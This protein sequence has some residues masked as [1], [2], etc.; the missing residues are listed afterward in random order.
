MKKRVADIIV[1]T[2]IEN[3]I[4]QAF[5]VVGGGAMHLNNAFALKRNILRTI[6]NHHE[7]ASAMAAEAYARLTGNLAVVCVTSGPGGLNTFNG[8]QSAWVDSLPMIVIAGHP[9]YDTTINASGLNVRCIGVQENDVIPQVQNITKYAKMVLDPRSVKAEVQKAI[10]LAMDCRRGPVWL[11]FPLDVQGALVEED[12]LYPTENLGLPLIHSAKEGVLEAYSILQASKRPCILTGSGIRTSNSIQEF[13]KFLQLF[14]VPIVGGFG[15]PDNNYNGEKNYFGISGSFGP[16]CGNFILQN[17]DCILV[18]GNSLSTNQT[19]F[20]VSAFAQKAKIIMVDAQEDESK[21]AGLHIKKS[22]VCDIKDFFN[23]YSLYCG[24][25]VASSEWMD[26]CNLLKNE[27]PFFEVL[28]YVPQDDPNVAVHPALFWKD[29]LNQVE[30][31]AIFALG[32]S[33]STHELL[34]TGTFSEEQ[35]IIE[36]YHSG[37][38]GIDLPFAIGAAAGAPDSPIYCVTGDGCFMM[39]LQELQT[40]NYHRFKIK[41]VIFNNNGYDNIRM[42]CRNYFQGLG[43]G[44]DEES[45]IS[46]PDFKKVAEAFGFD[47]FKVNNVSELKNGIDWLLS[48]KN[49]CILEIVEKQNKERAPLVKSVMNENGVFITPPIHIMSPLLSDDILKKCTKYC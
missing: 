6:Y 8:V 41:I 47:F 3:G 17:A 4:T 49:A 29:F 24:K 11:S 38:M 44:C 9:R 21:K 42:T 10:D 45:G 30:K 18:L 23:S 14:D 37:S 43:N 22:I 2:L 36:N 35:R 15:A 12:E 25:I 16:R 32:N 34:K 48:E 27:F 19:G 26:Y 7:Q 20:N 13:K 28:N 40:I 31:S 33:S 46:M 1:E 5:S 39:N